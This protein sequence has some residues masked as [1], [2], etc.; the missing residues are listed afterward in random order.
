MNKPWKVIL[1]FLGVFLAGAVFGGFLSLRVARHFFESAK[2]RGPVP[3]EQF[4]PQMFKRLAEKLELTPEQKEK[5]RPILKQT[6]EEMR[7]LRQ[8]GMRESMAVADRM[9]DEV[10]ALLTPEQKAKLESMKREMRERWTKDRQRRMG[11]RPPGPSR[12]DQSPA[13]PERP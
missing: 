11:D 8:S 10:S 12:E 2:P 3:L 6:E 1:A 4:S 5:I 13:P 9:H 7:R